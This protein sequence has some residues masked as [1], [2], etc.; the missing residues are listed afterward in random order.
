M[1][2]TINFSEYFKS[3]KEE[4]NPRKVAKSFHIYLT[5]PDEVE[6]C[7]E[8][9]SYDNW[10]DHYNAEISNLFDSELQLINMINTKAVTEK[11]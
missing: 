5:T 10:I 6:K 8:S 2:K 3:I 4:R 7:V 1:I 11:N 9:N